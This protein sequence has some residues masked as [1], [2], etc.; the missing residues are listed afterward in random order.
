VTHGKYLWR[1]WDPELKTI[2]GFLK[3]SM[4]TSFN[5][6]LLSRLLL[7]LGKEDLA[8][9]LPVV[10]VPVLSA[11]LVS[12]LAFAANQEHSKLSYQAAAFI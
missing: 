10:Q 4:S 3:E 6:S 12:F 5:F 1:L 2:D 7:E 11:L 9:L 8:S